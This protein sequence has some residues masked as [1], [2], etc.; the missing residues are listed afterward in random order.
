M[1]SGASKCFFLV[2]HF[3][4]LHFEGQLRPF[5]RPSGAKCIFVHFF[6][7]LLAELLL[8]RVYIFV[9]FPSKI[10]LQAF[11]HVCMVYG[12]VSSCGIIWIGN[13]MNCVSFP[14]IICQACSVSHACLWQPFKLLEH[15]IFGLIGVF[16]FL[17]QLPGGGGPGQQT[18]SPW[19][20]SKAHCNHRAAGAEKKRP[21]AGGKRTKQT[22]TSQ[23]N[24][25]EVN[26]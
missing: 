7:L 10:I 13:R 6:Q 16:L 15:L 8:R 11:F 25:N 3:F 22:C 4:F 19:S 26:P 12:D 14:P 5:F 17:G 21:S 20:A 18:G 23:E 9:H 2:L 24:R 1:L